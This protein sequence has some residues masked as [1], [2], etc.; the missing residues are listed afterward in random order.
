[1]ELT[2]RAT[3]NTA[4]LALIVALVSL[5]LSGY[6]LWLEPTRVNLRIREIEATNELTKNLVQLSEYMKQERDRYDAL[7]KEQKQ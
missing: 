3:S 2:Q 1:M 4:V 6:S 7:R 5:I